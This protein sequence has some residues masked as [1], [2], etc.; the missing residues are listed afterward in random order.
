MKIGG[1]EWDDA[2]LEHIARHAITPAEVEDVCFGTH[3][4]YHG[5]H[6]RYVLYG[7]ADNGKYIMLVLMHSYGTVLRPITAREMSES[8]KHAYRKSIRRTL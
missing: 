5:K 8:E 2:N 4:A 3:I 1:L 6:A 7:Q